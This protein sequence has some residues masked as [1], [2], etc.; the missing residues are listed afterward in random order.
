MA[1]K[2]IKKVNLNQIQEQ[3][4]QKNK[5]QVKKAIVTICGLIG[6]S[7]DKDSKTYNLTTKEATYSS[8]DEVELKGGNYINMLPLLIENK[9]N[10]YDLLALATKD[11]QSVQEMVLEHLAIDKS[12]VQFKSIDENK[13]TEYASYFGAITSILNEY[14]EITLDISHGFRH[15]PLL[16]IIALVI[17]NIS[18]TSKIKHIY[19]AQE[20]TPHEEYNIRD[21]L[22]YL[23]LA[24]IAFILS[25]F[26]KNYTVASHI[27]SKKHNNLINKLN[28]FSNDLMALSL[29]N[30]FEKS[31][32]EL[33]KELAKVENIS[34]KSQAQSLSEAIKLLSNYE[35][36]K[37]FQ[38]YFD[39]AKDLFK[40][41]YM[42]LS[43]SLLFESIRLY[44]RS[45]IE[46]EH[47]SLVD[48][49]EK[50]LNKD[51]YKI[52]DFFKNLQWK[53]FNEYQKDK[54][55]IDISEE[56]YN[57]LKKAY[58]KNITDLYD[59]VDKKRNN[60]AHANSDNKSFKDIKKEIKML[61]DEYEN[62]CI[63]EK[64]VNDL[65]NHFKG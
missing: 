45:S 49:V 46:K 51:R 8:Q 3:K 27:K 11:A 39:L 43:L 16:T 37:R 14:D 38:T 36:K 31:S 42:L 13:E 41:N 56:K 10:D 63:K 6:G 48:D 44:I 17:Q 26:E 7:Y 1:L 12:I 34:I 50:K 23:E 64:S 65:L 9:G 35:G 60:L 21:L 22:E 2:I 33:I 47:P 57:I 58:P 54:R 18:D 24:N 29:N 28:A 20:I 61:L 4:V 32:K 55:K 59:K 52:A 5:T 40:K 25:T 30:L 62:L 15:L 53:D 19:F